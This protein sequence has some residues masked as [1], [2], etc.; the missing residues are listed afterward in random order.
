MAANTFAGRTF[1]VCVLGA[2]PAGLAA[3]SR[4]VDHGRDV[5]ILDRATAQS[6]WGGETFTGAI[7]G[8]LSELGCWEAFERAGHVA[9]YE[10]QCAWG[11]EPRAENALFPAGGAAVAR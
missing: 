10:L 1:D 3:A 2:G 7:R 5:L 9:G 6:R 11:G 4:L 8:P